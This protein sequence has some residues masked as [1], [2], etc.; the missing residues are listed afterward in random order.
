MLPANLGFNNT[1]VS[2]HQALS[3]LLETVMYSDNFT[4]VYMAGLRI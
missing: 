4:T 1:Q 3:K 2:A